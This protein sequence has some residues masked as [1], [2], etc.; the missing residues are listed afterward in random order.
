MSKALITAALTTALWCGQA[1]AHARL[2]RATP[3]VGATVVQAP[4]ELRLWFSETIDLPLSDI[5]LIGPGGAPIALGPLRLEG[6]DPRVVIAPVAGGLAAGDYRVEWTM[7][8]ADTHRTDGDF[9][10]TVKPFLKVR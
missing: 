6:S 7:T 1:V 10:F 5:S 8:A 3:R 2:I 4:T 9:K